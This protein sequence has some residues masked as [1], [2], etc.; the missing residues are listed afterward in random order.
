MFSDE[1]KKELLLDDEKEMFD[2]LDPKDQQ[3]VLMALDV[4]HKIINIPLGVSAGGIR[5]MIKALELGRK[6]LPEGQEELEFAIEELRNILKE[7]I[8]A[9]TEAIAKRSKKDE[10]FH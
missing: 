6:E 5:L 3:S 10:T 1:F 9:V 4:E 2:K 8:V 7:L